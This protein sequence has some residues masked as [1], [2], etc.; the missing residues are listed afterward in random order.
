MEM[1]SL[2]TCLC[3]E[4]YTVQ[5]T[6]LQMQSDT[7]QSAVSDPVVKECVSSQSHTVDIGMYEADLW[8]RYGEFAHSEVVAKRIC[9]SVKGHQT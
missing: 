8:F 2:H 7:L 3:I 6:A 5:Y 4:V 1:Y 9:A